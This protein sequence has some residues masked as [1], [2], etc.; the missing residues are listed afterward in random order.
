MDARLLAEELYRS[1]K[2]QTIWK[3]VDIKRIDKFEKII[4]KHFTLALDEAI[5]KAIA[6]TPKQIVKIVKSDVETKLIEQND[7]VKDLVK[8]NNLSQ[9]TETLK[10]NRY[11]VQFWVLPHEDDTLPNFQLFIADPYTIAKTADKKGYFC[12]VDT[13][14][15]KLIYDNIKSHF[16]VA[17][18]IKCEQVANDY[19]PQ[20]YKKIWSNRTKI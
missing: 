9:Y 13:H 15:E 14:D 16:K 20:Y 10:E 4:Q 8:E 12:W 1:F 18:I 6:D 17:K 2:S 3:D 7:F 5:E 11:Y 19:I